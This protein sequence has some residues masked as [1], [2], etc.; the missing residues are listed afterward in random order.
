MDA[1]HKTFQFEILVLDT[2]A[3]CVVRTDENLLHAMLS[4]GTIWTK[5]V[6]D[7]VKKSICDNG[8]EVTV[9]SLTTPNDACETDTSGFDIRVTGP[10]ETLE[11]IRHTLVEH[12]E[13]IKFGPLYILKDEVSE[14]IACQI[15]PL[16]YRVENALRGYLIKFMS[17]R[18]GPKWWEVTATG[19]WSQKVHQRRFNETVFAEH[20]DNNAYLVDFGDLGRMIYEQ[21][22]GFT[23]KSD[24]IKKVSECEETPDAIRELKKQLQTNYQKFFKE[25]F[26]DKGFQDKWEK[27]EKIRHKVAHNNLFT[28]DDLDKGSALAEELLEI[29]QTATDAIDA[30]VIPEDEKEAIKSSFVSRGWTF[31]VITEDKFLSELE[32]QETYFHQRGGF[33]GLS[34]FV[35]QHLGY[36]GYDYYSSYDMASRLEAQ[37]KIEMYQEEHPTENYPVTAVRILRAPS[38]DVEESMKES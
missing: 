36:Q 31:D 29:I 32:K 28:K 21:S 24:I 34:H 33:V 15:Y 9:R 18:L 14:E 37:A 27:L 2:K 25:S 17:T 22:S 5:P 4:N 10:F 19:E 12:F 35:K 20:I 1:D 26:K 30:L 7:S 13:D 3:T 16:L 6:F 8:L 11:P 23:S 38:S